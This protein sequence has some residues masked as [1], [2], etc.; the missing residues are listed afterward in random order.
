MSPQI[1][2][3]E[4]I[5]TNYVSEIK[6]SNIYKGE[7]KAGQTIK[8]ELDLYRKPIGQN[9]YSAS[10]MQEGDKVFLFLDPTKDIPVWSGV[11]LIINDKVVGFSQYYGNPGPYV[12]ESFGI[13]TNT[14]IPTVAEFRQKIQD[15]ISR[16]DKWKS[17]LDRPA[18]NDDIPALLQL[19]RERGETLKGGRDEISEIICSHLAD[20]HNVDA[21]VEVLH[22]TNFGWG[23]YSIGRGFGTPAGREFLLTNI[24]NKNQPIAERRKYAGVLWLAGE[25]Y[26][27]TNNGS[28]WNASDR[29]A[30]KSNGHYLKRLAQIAAF[31]DLD[32]ELR[33]DL[34]KFFQNLPYNF[35]ADIPAVTEDMEDAESV[36]KWYLAKTTS[37]DLKYELEVALTKNRDE[38]QLDTNWPPIVS[39]LTP[40]NPQDN[41]H[42]PQSRLSFA[43]NLIRVREGSWNTRV[44]FVNTKTGHKWTASSSKSFEGRGQAG[45]TDEV[46]LPENLP[47]GHYRVFYEFLENGKVICTSHYFETDL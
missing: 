34:I 7:L 24:L 15:S 29:A 13:E 3:G 37:E 31:N 35:D 9:F 43:Y 17:L 11:K 5:R 12:A 2:E 38:S 39:I 30:I 36:L 44:A 19:L 25:V 40:R 6:V 16:T 45:G 46:T 41:Y 42:A 32:P 20:L 26:F 14:L 4:I 21:L 1:I 28:S 27:S 23:Y 18:S 10:R 22:G 33:L 8:T 47:H